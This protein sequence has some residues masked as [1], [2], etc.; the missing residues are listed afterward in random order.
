MQ[1]NI[2]GTICFTPSK[3]NSQFIQKH[4]CKEISHNLPPSCSVHRQGVGAVGTLQ[5]GVRRLRWRS[6]RN[7]TLEVSVH[8]THITITMN[9]YK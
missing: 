9:I 1:T 3:S 4:R 5:M 6:E 7:R 2:V 8:F